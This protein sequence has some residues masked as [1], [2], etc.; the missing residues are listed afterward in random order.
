M[1]AAKACAW[2]IRAFAR[3]AANRIVENRDGRHR[4]HVERLHGLPH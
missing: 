3:A 2:A 1:P 4:I